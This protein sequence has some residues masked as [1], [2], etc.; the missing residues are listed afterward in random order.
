MKY[1]FALS[2]LFLLLAACQSAD[3]ATAT[4]P[5]ATEEVALETVVEPAPTTAVPTALPTLPPP[6]TTL[7]AAATDVPPAE[8]PTTAPPEPTAM[9]ET[10]VTSLSLSPLINSGLIRPVYLTHAGDNR[11]FVVEQRGLIRVIIN[12]ELLVQPFLDIEERVGDAANEQGLLSVA[13]DPDYAMNGR[14]FV[15]YTDNNGNT[16][17]SRFQVTSDPNTG[18]ANSESILLTIAQ[19]FGNHN[20][21]QLLFGPDGALYIGMGDGGS[22][23]DPQSNGQNPNSLLGSI[24]RLDVN[25]DPYGIPADNPFLNNKTS[26]AEVWAVGFRNPWRFSF[27]RLTGDLFIADVGQNIW[28]EISFQPASSPGGENYGWNIMEG[29]HCYQ[30][31]ACQNAGM[32][33][34]I[35]EYDHALGCSVT[36]GYVYRGRQFPALSGNYFLGDYCTGIIWSLFQETDGTWTSHEVLRNTGLLIA[37][38][39]EDVHGELYVIDHNGGVWGIRPSD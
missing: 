32:I 16:V 15:N 7:E 26:R 35:F 17:I 19:P 36:G 20:G 2:L 31:A 28:E 25:Q 37:S 29:N 4:V 18:D 13:F 14:F 23:G 3:E 10:A 24:L 12:G 33:A 39:G 30:N 21:G 9:P 1:L 11:L 27:D 5:L 6:A 38:F 34:P 8:A 22:Q